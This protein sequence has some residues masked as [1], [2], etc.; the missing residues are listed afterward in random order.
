VKPNEITGIAIDCAMRIHTRLG[1]GL[2]ESVYETLRE[3]ELKK[4][5]LQVRRQFPI[6][7]VY[8]DIK[9]ED[10]F[11]G[12]LLVEDFVLVEIKSVETLAPV[13][14]KQVLTYLRC[15]DL[16]LGLLINFGSN[17]LKEG[18]RRIVNNLPES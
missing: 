1:P 11:R 5:G 14:Y 9:M 8:D 7:V 18:V 10:G 15:A 2:Y 12:D 17:Q 3:Y 6:P 4:A 16:R 13:H